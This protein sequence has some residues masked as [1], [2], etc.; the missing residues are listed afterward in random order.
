MDTALAPGITASPPS[1]L[2]QRGPTA[3]DPSSAR[4]LLDTTVVTPEAVVLT[5][6]LAGIGSRVL[7]KLLDLMIQGVGFTLLAIVAGFL[8]AAVGGD[9]I[10]IIIIVVAIFLIVYGYPAVMEAFWGGQTVGKMAM[11]L[12]VIT[13]EG[14]PISLRHSAIRSMLA[15]FDFLIP[16]PGGLVALV[17]ALLTKRGQR[18]GDLAA[19]TIVVRESNGVLRP[20]VFSP[21]YGAEV[22]NKLLDTS[23]LSERQYTVIREFLVRSGELDTAARY[24]LGERLATKV[25]EATG[26]E[27]PPGLDAERYLV[28]ILLAHQNRYRDHS[29]PAPAPAAPPPHGGM[30]PGSPPVGLVPGA[31][32]A[33]APGGWDLQNLP[34]PSGPPAF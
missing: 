29:T 7:A 4:S 17:L 10:L 33:S 22:F 5:F 8:A 27:R 18:V 28:S 32:P 12:R 20:I 9:T 3:A 16:A 14:G 23:L 31:V 6:R 21:P 1:R 11:G 13:I 26:N 24:Q 15:T 19:G 34:P 30:V 25:V 2:I